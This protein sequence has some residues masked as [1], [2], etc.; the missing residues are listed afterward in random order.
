MNELASRQH[1]ILTDYAAGPNRLEAALAGLPTAGL[2]LALSGDNWTIRQIV[3]HVTDGDDIWKVFIKRAIGH[4]GGEFS[5]QWY[6]QIPQDEW[7]EQWAYEKRAIEPSLALFRASRCHIV[8]LLE[9]V[10]EAWGKSLRV[11]WPSGEEQQV[12]VIWVVEMQARHVVGHIGDIRR[13]REVY[14]I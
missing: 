13:I 10:P 6:W 5:L 3:H 12:S 4:P 9:H 11:R 8:Q 1:D 14:C 7:A 2:D